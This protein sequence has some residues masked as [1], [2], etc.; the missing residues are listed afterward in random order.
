LVDR[1]S[2]LKTYRNAFE[3]ITDQ[4]EAYRQ[5][6]IPNGKITEH[7]INLQD[8]IEAKDFRSSYMRALS[9]KKKDLGWPK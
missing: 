6:K 7:L 5:F 1:R 2:N 3:K 8:A 4:I 9:V